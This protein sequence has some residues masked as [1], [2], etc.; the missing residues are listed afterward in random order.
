MQ[1]AGLLRAPRS[2]RLV[3]SI[4]SARVLRTLA[5]GCALS[6]APSVAHGQRGLMTAQ[7]LR[8][9]AHAGLT[10]SVARP[11]VTLS[12]AAVVLRD[13]LVTLARKQVGRRYVLGGTTPRGGFD[14]SGLIRYVAAR[15][16]IPLPRTAAEQARVGVRVASDTSALMPGDLLT[17]GRGKVSHVGIYVG[18]GR[19]VHASSEAGRVIETRLDRNVKYLP[20]RGARRVV[21]SPPPE[22]RWLQ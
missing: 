20:L 9:D 6:L 13:S 1:P 7:P 19:M 22:A 2:N 11:F 5:L 10:R 3:D 4:R 21:A 8:G 12:D 17:F 18:N 15:L 16:D 14:C